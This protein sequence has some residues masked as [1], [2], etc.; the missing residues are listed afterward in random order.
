MSFVLIRS[1][2]GG[3]GH[4]GQSATLTIILL[5]IESKLDPYTGTGVAMI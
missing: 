4:C 2:R 5:H 1:E 3:G